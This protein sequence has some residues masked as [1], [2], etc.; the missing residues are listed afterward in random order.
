ML[1]WNLARI[2]SQE[3]LDKP[4]SNP[5]YLSDDYK[6]SGGTTVPRKLL[7]YRSVVVKTNWCSQPKNKTLTNVIES[8]LWQ[9]DTL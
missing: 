7:A 1:I 3:E 5:Q 6:A 2:I 8:W 9:Q 4:G